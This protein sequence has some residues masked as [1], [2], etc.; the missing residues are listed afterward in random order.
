MSSTNSGF[1]AKENVLKKNVPDTTESQKTFQTSERC[2][3]KRCK[4][5]IV[6]R[7]HLCIAPSYLR[8]ASMIYLRIF[9]VV[10]PML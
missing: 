6:E 7:S 9:K 10:N 4:Q 1:P 5:D 3:G 8:K 2:L